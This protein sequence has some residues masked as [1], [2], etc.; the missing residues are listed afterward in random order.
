LTVPIFGDKL[1]V[2]RKSI[3]AKPAYRAVLSRILARSL[4]ALKPA[5]IKK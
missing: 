5:S 2:E 3:D 4:K 1:K